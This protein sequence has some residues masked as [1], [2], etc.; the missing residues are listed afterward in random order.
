MSTA[1]YTGDTLELHYYPELAVPQSEYLLYEDDGAD[2][3]AL[4]LGL[5]AALR[6]HGTTEASRVSMQLEVV[7]DG[8]TGSPD[9]AADA[10]CHPSNHR[11]TG[12]RLCG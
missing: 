12:F 6:F 5:Y 4:E 1:E 8:Y 2:P 3:S 10:V 7:H 11:R 9:R